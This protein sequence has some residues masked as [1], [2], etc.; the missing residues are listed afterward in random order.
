MYIYIKSFTVAEWLA[1]T[2]ICI[3]I[4]QII[5]SIHIHQIIS[6]RSQTICD[7]IY[8]YLWQKYMYMCIKSLAIWYMWTYIYILYG[9]NSYLEPTSIMLKKSCYWPT[10]FIK[11]F[12]HFMLVYNTISHLLK[13]YRARQL[14]ITQ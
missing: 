9:R 13:G 3:Y 1:R 5:R 6:Y 12:P 8:D 11:R 2:E 4:H 7:R 10:H 14:K